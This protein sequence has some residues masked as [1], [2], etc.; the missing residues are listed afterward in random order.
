MNGLDFMGMALDLKNHVIEK[1]G[2][3]I[4]LITVTGSVADESYNQY[5]DID[6]NI[7][8]EDTVSHEEL[9][10]PSK[11]FIQNIPISIS[12]G[13]WD[14]IEGLVNMRQLPY[15]PLIISVISKSRV[16]YA[17]SGEERIRLRNYKKK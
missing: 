16:I 13:N 11:L 17:K 14:R 2:D 15:W 4:S 10:F 1:Y 7:I 3:Q 6:F 5:S 12:R 8:L 9:T